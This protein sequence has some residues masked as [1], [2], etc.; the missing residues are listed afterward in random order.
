MQININKF[1]FLYPN[2]V[3]TNRQYGLKY[4][5]LAPL[6]QDTVSF[7]GRGKLIAESMVDAPP[8]RTCRQVEINAE[9]ARF[10]LESVL[11]EYLKPL[12]QVNSD[13]NPKEFPILECTTRVK[14][15]TSI[16]EKVVSKYSKIYT[17][18]AD[19]FSERVVDELLKYFKLRDGISRDSV[20]Q[21]AKKNIASKVPPYEF[22]SYYFSTITSDFKEKNCFNFSDYSE[23]KMKQIFAQ[24]TD[25]LEEVPKSPHTDGSVYIE[26]EN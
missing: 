26:E 23:E 12:T 6:A 8:E 13:S 18:E 16:R 7:S 24:I 19:E 2:T 5:N 1:H 10:Y 25:T 4:P 11:N 20:V 9:P 3:N 22:A 17:A 15:S 21:E 14:K